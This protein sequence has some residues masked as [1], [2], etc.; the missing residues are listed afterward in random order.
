[1]KHRVLVIDDERDL[2]SLILRILSEADYETDCAH[3]LAEGIK[4]WED[5]QPAIVL[6]DN[7]LPDG[8][9][10]ELLELNAHLLKK[11]LT[12]L[13]T[14]DTQ[15]TTKDKATALGI[16]VFINKPFSML[17]IRKVVESFQERA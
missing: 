11:S 17:E 5:W 2:C 10:L 4:K 15:E 12:I 3:T 7:N 1:M 13:I 8:T 16:P 6:L 9:G 14:A